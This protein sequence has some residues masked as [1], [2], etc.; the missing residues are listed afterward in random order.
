M[1]HSIFRHVPTTAFAKH[2]SS[3]TDRPPIEVEDWIDEHMTTTE[4][5]RRKLSSAL[6]TGLTFTIH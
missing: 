4:D 2:G 1:S 6:V 3:P 5:N